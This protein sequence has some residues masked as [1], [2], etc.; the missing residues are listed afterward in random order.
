MANQGRRSFLPKF[1]VSLKGDSSKNPRAF[2]ANQE[3][4]EKPLT[5]WGELSRSVP[6]SPAAAIAP[7]TSNFFFIL[8]GFSFW[9][10]PVRET[11]Y[12]DKA[13]SPTVK[14]LKRAVSSHF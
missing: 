9:V 6:A 7:T 14:P 8:I 2:Y 4:L 3:F 1:M 5:F 11:V 10:F 12:K 13:L